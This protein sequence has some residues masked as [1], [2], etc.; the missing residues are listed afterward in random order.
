MKG[1]RVAEGPELSWGSPPCELDC[2]CGGGFLQS[3]VVPEFLCLRMPFHWDLFP[4][5]LQLGSS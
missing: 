4:K 2:L 5:D 1:R 3:Y